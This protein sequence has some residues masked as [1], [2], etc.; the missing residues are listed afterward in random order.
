MI[1]VRLLNLLSTL[2]LGAFL[3]TY[4]NSVMKHI[5]E[6]KRHLHISAQKEMEQ[7]TSAQRL[8]E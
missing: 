2:V 5:A 6:K 8:E 7:R 4:R 1:N 3:I